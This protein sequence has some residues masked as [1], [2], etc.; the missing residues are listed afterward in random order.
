MYGVA[1]GIVGGSGNEMVL[2]REAWHWPGLDRHLQIGS[3]ATSRLTWPKLA[4][5]LSLLLIIDINNIIESKVRSNP[6][7]N[8]LRTDTCIPISL[9]LSL[10]PRSLP[11]FRGLKSQLIIHISKVYNI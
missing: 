11:Q 5:L 1:W 9:L 6:P 3:R 2:V 7:Y 8:M 4:Q 10:L